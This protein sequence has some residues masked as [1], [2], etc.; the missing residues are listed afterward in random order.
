M[1][2]IPEIL[3]QKN[4]YALTIIVS[5]CG[6]AVHKIILNT[7]NFFYIVKSKL[8]QGP[9]LWIPFIIINFSNSGIIKILQLQ[10]LGNEVS[11]RK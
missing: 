4:P 11:K 1:I 10:T 2:I 5:N 6:D 8:F 3:F 7:I 9:G